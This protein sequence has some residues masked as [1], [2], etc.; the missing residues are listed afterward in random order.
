MNTT[1]PAAFSYAGDYIREDIEAGGMTIQFY[2]G[3]KHQA[4]MEAAKAWTR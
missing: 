3:H 1:A 2:Y 4:V